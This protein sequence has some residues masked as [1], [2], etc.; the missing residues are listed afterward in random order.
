[1][2]TES[3]YSQTNKLTFIYCE[4]CG[5]FKNLYLDTDAGQLDCISFVDGVGNFDT[6]KSKSTIIEIENIKLNILDIDALIEAKKA[7]N[8]KK[9]LQAIVELEAIIA[10]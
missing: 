2:L 10:I 3:S 9:D 7:L 6:V 1:M 5:Q 8:R 4:N